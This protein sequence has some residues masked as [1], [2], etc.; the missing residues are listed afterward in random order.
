MRSC[1][2]FCPWLL[3]NQTMPEM[4]R[5]SLGFFIFFISFLSNSLSCLFISVFKVRSERGLVILIS[6]GLCP[7]Y[8]VLY[9]HSRNLFALDWESFLLRGK[10]RLLKYQEEASHVVITHLRNNRLRWSLKLSILLKDTGVRTHTAM[11]C[12]YNEVQSLFTGKKTIF[13]V[14]EY[15][16]GKTVVQDKLWDWSGAVVQRVNCE[17]K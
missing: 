14:A 17:N 9:L 3:V 6:N 4:D 15:P 5:F 11:R 8:R 1:L 2:F 10:Q 16:S 7:T 13:T 12:H